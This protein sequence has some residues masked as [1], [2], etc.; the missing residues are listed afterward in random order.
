MQKEAL[1]RKFADS[2]GHYTQGAYNT[3]PDNKWCCDTCHKDYTITYRSRHVKD[4]HSTA[5]EL[6]MKNATQPVNLTPVENHPASFTLNSPALSDVTY[7]SE[8]LNDK[9]PAFSPTVPLS[10]SITRLAKEQQGQV[11]APLNLR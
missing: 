8:D 5:L 1:V 9:E 10:K 7:I 3:N 2:I 11:T 4:I 6:F